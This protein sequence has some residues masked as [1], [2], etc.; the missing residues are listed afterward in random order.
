MN[1]ESCQEEKK[2]EKGEKRERKRRTLNLLEKY[3]VNFAYLRAQI[4]ARF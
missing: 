1:N 2:E 4:W 3:S